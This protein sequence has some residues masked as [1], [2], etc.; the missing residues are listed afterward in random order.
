MNSTT[1]LILENILFN[2]QFLVF[3]KQRASS[4]NSRKI[5]LEKRVMQ[6]NKNEGVL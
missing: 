5:I 6:K 2:Q 1:Q 4:M 3:T